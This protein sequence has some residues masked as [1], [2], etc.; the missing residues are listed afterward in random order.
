M[1]VQKALL[2]ENTGF[3]GIIT[4]KTMVPKTSGWQ[5]KKR[6]FVTLWW[7]PESFW[8]VQLCWGKEKKKKVESGKL[9]Q[10]SLGEYGSEYFLNLREKINV[11]SEELS[12]PLKMKW[13]PRC[14]TL[15]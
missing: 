10:N 1:A 6:L 4:A 14:R 15:V 9:N 3:N 13:G 7:K 11:G 5:M 12:L 2:T 8:L